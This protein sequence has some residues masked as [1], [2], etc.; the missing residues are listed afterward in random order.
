MY[1]SQHLNVKALSLFLVSH[2]RWENY[3]LI[4]IYLYEHSS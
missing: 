3:N 4:G 1:D 2:R